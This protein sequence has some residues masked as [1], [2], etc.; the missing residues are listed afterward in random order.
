MDLVRFLVR[1]EPGM[2]HPE[3]LIV[4]NG[5]NLADIVGEIERPLVERDGSDP[6]IVGSYAGYTTAQLYDTVSRHFLGSEN[7]H[8]HCGP[9][10]KTALLDCTARLR[11]WVSRQLD[12]DG[13]SHRDREHGHLV[14]V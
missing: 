14:A 1:P 9:E 10:G 13:P 2:P 3:I 5:R 12:T 6:S 11:V 8:L 7:S 4:V